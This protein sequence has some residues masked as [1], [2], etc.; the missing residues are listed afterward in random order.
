MGGKTHVAN[1][2]DGSAQIV[3][4]DPVGNS[5]VLSVDA[6]GRKV[7]GASLSGQRITPASADQM[8]NGQPPG[9]AIHRPQG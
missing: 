6:E 2:D 4:T 3:W 1:L 7:L 8:P 5:V 9:A